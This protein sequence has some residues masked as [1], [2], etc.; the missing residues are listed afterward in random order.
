MIDFPYTEG[1]FEVTSGRTEFIELASGGVIA[2]ERS[3]R[4]VIPQLQ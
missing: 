3:E 4:G 2:S 1:L